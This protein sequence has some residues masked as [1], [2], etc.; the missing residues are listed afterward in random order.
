MLRRIIV[1]AAFALSAAVVQ[2]QTAPAM[3]VQ[4]LQAPQL[5]QI[6]QEALEKVRLE[7]E[8]KRLKEENAALKKQVDDFT[9]LGGSNVHA[10]CAN[11]TTSRNTAGAEESC[12]ANLKCDAIT[13]Q[14]KTS[15]TTSSD[16]AVGACE[17]CGSDTQGVCATASTGRCG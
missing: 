17:I 3:Q 10:Y 5:N 7:R 15:C 16:C 4:R 1:V 14:C 12:G 6:D 13:G 11:P 8:N 2:A 9:A